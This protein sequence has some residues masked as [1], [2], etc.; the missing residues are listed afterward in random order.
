MAQRLWSRVFAGREDELSELLAAM[1]QA[2]AGVPLVALIGGEAGIG[3]SRLLAE[4]VARAADGGALVLRGQCASLDGAAIPLLPVVDAL[5]GL[6]EDDDRERILATTP[7]GPASAQLAGGPV[8]RLHALVLDQ[9]ASTAASTPVLLVLEDLHWA[10]RSTLDVVAFLAR[11]LRRERI[12]VVASY[13]SDEVDRRPELQRLLGDTATAPTSQRLELRGLTRDEMRLQLSGILGEPP[14]EALL[15]AVFDRSG[16]NPFFAEEL[17]AVA[18]SG[19]PAGLSPTLRDALLTRVAALDAHAEAVVRAA[20]AGGGKVHHRLLA[21]AAGIPEPELTEAL[22][23]AIRHHVLMADDDE[24]SFRHALLQEVVYAELLPGERARL[25]PRSPP[26]SRPVPTWP[27]PPPPSPP[28]SRTTGSAPA[29]RPAPWPRPCAQATRP[30]AWARSP[31]PPASTG[32]RS[33]CGPRCPA[34]SWP[35]VSTGPRCLHARP[36]R[37]PGSGIRRRRSGSST[38]RSRSS[39]RTA[40]PFAQRS[41]TSDEGCTCG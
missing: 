24:L 26:R 5:S 21:T 30:S 18:G 32:A 41:S 27:A 39:T 11:R 1:E 14:S 12:L 25:H 7:T 2:A 20:A 35:R 23:A 4:L 16:G 38:R 10:D 9:L 37:R 8:A 19:S 33:S 22:R 40:N 15:G 28:R 31:R 36:P 13:R 29:T 17:V 3:K 6:H 34:P